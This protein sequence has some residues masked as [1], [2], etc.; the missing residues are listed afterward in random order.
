M[1]NGNMAT[2]R[3]RAGVGGQALAPRGTGRTA[4]AGY[5]CGSKGVKKPR[6]YQSGS[7]SAKKPRKHSV[8]M[9]PQRQKAARAKSAAAAKAVQGAGILGY[10]SSQQ[11]VR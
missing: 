8:S 6:G 7:Q 3:R 5:K 11:K 9:S 4:M 2:P 10:L 1:L